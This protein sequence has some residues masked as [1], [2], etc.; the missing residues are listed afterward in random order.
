MVSSNIVGYSK[1]TMNADGYTLIANPF[2]DVATGNVIAINDMFTEDTTEA[3]A[4]TSAS[5]ADSIQVW[6]GTG[7][8]TYYLR[9]DSKGNHWRKVGERNATTDSIPEGEG[10]FYQNVGSSPVTLTVS[11]EVAAED[12]TFTIVPGYN[13]MAN[14]FPAEC[15]FDNFVVEG[16]IAGTSASNADSIQVWNGTG[17][18]TYYLRSDSK[19]NHWRKVGERAKTTDTI[20][21]YTGFFYQCLATS[22]SFTVTIP[23]PLKASATQE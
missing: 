10:A 5:N 6:N 3:T 17:Y 22:G 16:A 7:Y 18:T 13:L 1:L 21:P 20:A 4:G 9:S 23:S 19:G 8:T 15:S 12:S 11:G 14:P 2:V